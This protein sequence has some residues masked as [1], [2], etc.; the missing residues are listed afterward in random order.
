MDVVQRVNDLPVGGVVPQHTHPGPNFNILVQG[1]IVLNMQGTAN[2]F[3][4]GDSWVEPPDVVH[5][6]NNTG[7]TPAR[8]V[9]SAL[10][11]RG[12][13]VATPVQQPA[14]AAPA[15]AQPAPAAPARPAAAPPA[16][17]PGQLPKTGDLPLPAVPGLLGLGLLTGGAMLR[18]LR[19]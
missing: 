18:R 5:G 11:P 19:R 3:K 10:V 12:A 14:A 9:G 2:N 4:P 6:G 13:P 15:A 16:Q 8:T 17:V 7:S 1:Q